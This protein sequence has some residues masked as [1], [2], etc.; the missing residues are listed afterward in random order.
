MSLS[1]PIQKRNIVRKAMAASGD[2]ATAVLL[3]MNPGQE[4]FTM[5][6]GTINQVL[7]K[8]T[9][10]RLSQRLVTVPSSYDG[11]AVSLKIPVLGSSQ[12]DVFGLQ[13]RYQSVTYTYFHVLF[14]FLKFCIMLHH[15]ILLFT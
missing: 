5:Q 13:V 11:S 12:T 15:A 1:F 6:V 8:D 3:S 7:K 10:A 14:T 4:P 2:V 9:A